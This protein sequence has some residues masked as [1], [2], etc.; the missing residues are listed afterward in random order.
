VFCLSYAVFGVT[1]E[2]YGWSVLP[3]NGFGW[4]DAYCELMVGVSVHPF[5]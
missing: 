5:L 3:E 1:G 4:V 2:C